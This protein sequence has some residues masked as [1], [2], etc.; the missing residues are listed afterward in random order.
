MFFGPVG[1]S[2]ADLS[3]PQSW[4][5]YAYVLNNPA[6]NTD[7]S[8]LDCLYLSS[9][10]ASSI[11]VATERGN[12]TKGGGIYINGTVDV[13]SFTYTGASLGY[14]FTNGQAGGAGVIDLSGGPSSGQQALQTL[15][16]AGRWASTGL[17][18]AAISMGIN[19]ALAGVGVG[20]G[21]L[22]ELGAPAVET[23]AMTPE[24]AEAGEVVQKASGT[25]GNQTV[26][27]SSE[28][29]AKA[30]ADKFLGPDKEPIFD[31]RTGEFS[32]WQNSRGD[33]VVIDTHS[34]ALGP[35]MNFH[36]KVTGGNLHV[37][38]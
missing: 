21:I 12:C 38:W 37:R 33:R 35:H 7:P 27:V 19:G 25:V 9:Q 13:N 15:S 5:A 18:N 11:T 29:V 36:N 2:A 14:S 32:G 17:R 34:D 20:L 31:R 30:A 24:L 28:N 4:N 23:P 6:T 3:N 16:L 10:S 22:R 8:G 26:T 1:K